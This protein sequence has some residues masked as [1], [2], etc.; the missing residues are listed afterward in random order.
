M[1]HYQEAT[2]ARDHDTFVVTV[3]VGSAFVC[4][5]IAGRAPGAACADPRRIADEMMDETLLAMG[6]RI[7][8]RPAACERVVTPANGARTFWDTENREWRA[9]SRDDREERPAL[10]VQSWMQRAHS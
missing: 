8:G 6:F 3:R 7:V 5:A 1:S 9:H 4:D 2:I 10:K